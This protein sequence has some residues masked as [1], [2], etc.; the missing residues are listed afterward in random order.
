MASSSA[1][2]GKRFHLVSASRSS[3]HKGGSDASSGRDTDTHLIV[4]TQLGLPSMMVSTT[5]I[6]CRTSFR[7]AG[8]IPRHKCWLVSSHRHI[9][10][11]VPCSPPISVSDTCSSNLRSSNPL[12][13]ITFGFGYRL[14]SSSA[15]VCL[16]TSN[17]PP[18]TPLDI[19]MTLR[20]HNTR[21]YIRFVPKFVLLTQVCYGHIR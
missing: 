8:T 2:I 10:A 9:C 18:P 19:F 13:V 20:F 17:P 1:A 4:F 12:H 14:Y 6:D 5:A 16:R 21:N 15:D 7:D 3:A 11:K